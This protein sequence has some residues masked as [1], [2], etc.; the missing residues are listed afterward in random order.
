MK[1]TK[2]SIC[3]LFLA[4]LLT[5]LPMFGSLAETTTPDYVN[6]AGVFPISKDPNITIRLAVPATP[7][8]EDYETNYYTLWLEERL[9]CNLE[10]E[11]WAMSEMEQKTQVALSAASDLPDAI[12]GLPKSG[13]SMFSVTN[14][15]RYGDEG[16]IIPLNDYIEKY[17]DG[18]LEAYNQY[19]TGTTLQQQITSADGNVYI[20]PVLVVGKISRTSHKLWLNQNWLEKLNL[21]EPTTTEELY[22]V[23]KAF[24][25]QDPNGNGIADEIPL[26]GTNEGLY[27]N[28]VDY[29]MGSFIENNKKG[30]YLIADADG[31]L[32]FG[33]VADAWREGLK[34]I[35][36]LTSEGLLDPLTFTESQQELKQIA[37]SEEDICGGFVSLGLNHI[38]SE[39]A[40]AARYV[41]V[42]PVEGPEGVRLA[43]DNPPLA[44]GAGVIT[45]DCK[46]PEIVYRLFDLMMTDEACRAARYGEENVDWTYP[47]EGELDRFGNPATLKVLVDNWGKPQNKIWWGL[48]PYISDKYNDGAVGSSFPLSE[49]KNGIASARYID[50][51]SDK[52]VGLIIYPLEVV[53]RVNELTVTLKD[54]VSQSIAQFA[55]GVKDPNS[56][57]DWEAYLKEFD[58]IGLDEFLELAQASFDVMNK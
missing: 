43:I 16:T 32:S 44:D 3:S 19:T 54:Y 48:A 31:K 21:K 38:V 8:I 46:Y 4:L 40:I 30:N 6:P 53:D 9:G 12:L 27:Y 49:Q 45:C 52:T 42:L 55:V 24:K 57:A 34:F 7:N 20:M 47:E 25:T 36:R 41:D 1:R 37:N 39:D 2:T 29:I 58:A 17:G 15:I 50:Y 51:I 22:E 23:L 5:V 10:F 11:T 33:P 13:S 28:P 35:N 26:I 56:D 18:L 14:V